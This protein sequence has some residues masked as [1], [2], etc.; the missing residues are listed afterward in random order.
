MV[1]NALVSHIRNVLKMKEGGKYDLSDFSI[2]EFA[3]DFEDIVQT[4]NEANR[5]PARAAY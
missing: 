3:E 5:A 4:K 1:S 2:A